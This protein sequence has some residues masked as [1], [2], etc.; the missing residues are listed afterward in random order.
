MHSSLLKLWRLTTTDYAGYHLTV[1]MTYTYSDEL[2]LSPYSMF[3]VVP[4]RGADGEDY[5]S[6]AQFRLIGTIVLG[7]DLV[8]IR[9]GN[10]ISDGYNP[11]DL[12]GRAEH[13]RDKPLPPHL[14]F[15]ELDEGDPNDACAFLNA[16]G[17][18]EGTADYRS[19][20]TDER[21]QWEE[22]ASKSP[23]PE[24]HFR[25]TLGEVLLPDP[26]T[27]QDDHYGYSLK[28]FWK[29]QSD[30]ELT[31]RLH[32]ALDAPTN[33]LQKI[34]RILA[35][36]KAKC[37]ARG[38]NRERQYVNVAR[39]FVMTT[40]NSH[41]STLQP[42]VARLP[43]TSSVTGVWG[44][45]SLLQ[46]MYLMLFLDIA[47]WSGRIAQCEKCQSLFYTALDRGKY[48]TPVC[49]NRARALR[50]YHNKKGGS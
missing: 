31:L 39:E 45:Y 13:A 34:Q 14:V 24:V 50:A 27:P 12:Y 47:G 33:R 36:K 23:S 3:S 40:M 8:G 18:L 9:G 38:P 48:C 46:A 21:Q 2:P 15:A 49:E 30:F 10:G 35:A 20:N 11:F 5:P 25:S 26:A 37:D 7:E 19:L 6:L 43:N 29:A 22:A 4:E 1:N 42:R 16:Y 44:C 17:P 41:L 32:A 28:Q